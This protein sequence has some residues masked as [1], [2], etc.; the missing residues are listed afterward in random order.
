MY[1][2]G[3]PPFT[4]GYPRLRMHMWDKNN[5]RI[6]GIDPGYSTGIVMIEITND[7][8]RILTHTTIE[9][10]SPIKYIIDLLYSFPTSKVIIERAPDFGDP[11]QAVRVNKITTAIME[12]NRDIVF[13]SP[14]EW[15]P[16]ARASNWSYPTAN[17]QHEKDAYCI[18]KYFAV[19]K[20]KK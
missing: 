4:G 18:A 10:K 2:L 16:I 20:V 14:G 19:F 15:K 8:S 1:I 6:I 17:S 3:Y 9:G 7:D 12:I 13:I 11:S 5:I